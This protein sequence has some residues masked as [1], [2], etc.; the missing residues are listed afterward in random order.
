MPKI[1]FIPS[2]TPLRGIAAILV[3]FFHFSIFASPLLPS[4][5]PLIGKWY[6]M[7]D[8]F[9]VL[10]GFIMYHVYG[11]WFEDSIKRPAF[12]KYM[13]ARFARLYPLHLFMFLFML[14][15]FFV[16]NYRF[17]YEELPGIFQSILDPKAIPTTLLLVQGW[18]FH[19]EATWNTA[20]WS[21]SVEWFLYLL[22]PF[23][24][25]FLVRF[26]KVGSW[27]LF[28]LAFAGMLFLIYYVH[29]AYDLALAESRG[30]PANPLA[31]PSYSFDF[32][33]GP[34]LGRGFCGFV[35]GLL[36]YELYRKDWQRKLLS[37]GFWFPILWIGMM[38]LW[39]FDLLPDYIAVLLF[40]LLILSSAFA[41]GRV[42]KILNNRLFTFLG[43]ISYSIYMVHI[44]LLLVN[45]FIGMLIAGRFQGF[46]G[47][48]NPVFMD[49]LKAWG[50]A[51]VFLLLVIGVATLT[52]TYIEKP[53]RRRLKQYFQK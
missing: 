25:L 1:T 46:G 45:M 17:G 23:L 33:S 2:L 6:L 53:W 51:F 30:F 10:S 19:L 38:T 21:I 24:I 43:D 11:S 50:M 27:M 49:Y 4:D 22:F 31:P 26:K 3:V 9:F 14:A 36:C 47:V 28:A 7:V 13:Q 40:G 41:E 42:K 32:I 39:S 15:W 12:L 18:G 37:K 34:A 20:S 35:I 52:Y 8:M 44:P 48:E 29:P 16:L 5:N